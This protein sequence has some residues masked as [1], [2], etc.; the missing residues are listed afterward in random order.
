MSKELREAA[1]KI[2]AYKGTLGEE[3]LSV[4]HGPQFARAYLEEHPLDDQ[5]PV[6]E[7]WLRNVGFEDGNPSFY[8]LGEASVCQWEGRWFFYIDGCGGPDPLTHGHIRAFCK[9]LGIEL[10]KTHA[11]ERQTRLHDAIRALAN[12]QQEEKK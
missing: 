3:R 10:E 6:T 9:A 4:L 12:P 7:E 5:E 2:V 11:E 8:E 1:E